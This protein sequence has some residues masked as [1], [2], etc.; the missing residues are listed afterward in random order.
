V[1]SNKD[2]EV[3]FM[4]ESQNIEYKES[5]RDEYLKWVC[6][7]ANAQGG[8]IYIGLNDDDNVADVIVFSKYR[9]KGYGAKGLEFLCAAAKE[10]GISVIY[11]DIAID[12]PAISLFLKQGFYE[13]YRTEDKIILKKTL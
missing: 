13:E 8:T 6:G 3:W 12:N 7:F 2:V 11:D 10:N 9:G 4:A 1:T 5:W